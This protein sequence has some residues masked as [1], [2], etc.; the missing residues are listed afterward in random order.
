MPSEYDQLREDYENLYTQYSQLA[1]E[2]VRLAR[3]A[4]TH[5][6][7]FPDGFDEYLGKALRASWLAPKDP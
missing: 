5:G 6:F 1:R 2:F 4:D 3:F 7:K